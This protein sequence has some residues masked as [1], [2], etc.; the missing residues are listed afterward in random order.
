MQNNKPDYYND[1]EKIYSKVCKLLNLG[2]LKSSSSFHLPIFI[3]G[4][5]FCTCYLGYLLYNDTQ[6]SEDSQKQ[7]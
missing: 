4:F 1:L 3:C 6:Y 7:K 5:I 2:L